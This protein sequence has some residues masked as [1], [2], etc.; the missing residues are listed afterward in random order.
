MNAENSMMF[1]IRDENLKEALVKALQ[2]NFSDNLRNRNQ[3]VKL[4]SKIRGYLG[5]ILICEI[6]SN[7]N[8]SVIN[9]GVSGEDET[10]ID[11]VLANDRHRDLKMEVKTSLIPDAWGDL[12][13]VFN[14]G[15]IK[16]I[17]REEDYRDIKS[18]FHVQIYFNKLTKR[19]DSFLE[20]IVG[21][22][23]DYN[24]DQLID[25]MKLRE[26]QH[27]FVAWIDKNTLIQKLDSRE[28]A[29]RKWRFS[30]RTFWSCEIKD[31]R[32]Y[33]DF[34]EGIRLYQRRL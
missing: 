34:V 2:Q 6:L 25:V 20:G 29:N 9:T 19:R 11:I 5:E 12:G 28:H 10:D 14:K 15:D 8:I 21:E 27:F 17:Q 26:L 33:D 31:S 30:S 18:D 4:D 7:N 24:H 1:D 16:I 22:V 23:E 32:G 13:N 3:F